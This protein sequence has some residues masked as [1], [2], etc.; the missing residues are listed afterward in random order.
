MKKLEKSLV[1]LAGECAVASQLCR[2]G[3]YAQLTLGNRKKVDLLLD[4]EKAIARVEVKT[5]Q[6]RKWPGV[7][8]IAPKDGLTFLVL[9]DLQGKGEGERPEFYV[10]SQDEWG[11]FLVQKLQDKLK[12]GLVKISD[13]NV[14]QYP[15]RYVG[16]GITA[17]EVEKFRDDWGKIVRVVGPAK[18]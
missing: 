11:P 3:V 1:G 15:H 8:G 13:D 10:I 2:R 6:G 4:G 7:K 9:V 5:K 18:G 17:T 16:V 12:K 14:A